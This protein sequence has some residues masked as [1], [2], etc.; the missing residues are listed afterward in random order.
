MIFKPGKNQL[1]GFTETASCNKELSG[2]WKT[3]FWGFSKIEIKFVLDY[4]A[5]IKIFLFNWIY[6]ILILFL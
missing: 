3:I 5:K 4:Y 2:G 1:S 6:K